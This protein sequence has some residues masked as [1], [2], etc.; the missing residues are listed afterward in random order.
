VAGWF[1]AV[2]AGFPA[3]RPVIQN[4]VVV[5]LHSQWGFSAPN[6]EVQNL[7]A[8]GTKKQRE[9]KSSEN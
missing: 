4:L 6:P 7:A 8:A 5:F 3:E 1:A 9:L 2:A